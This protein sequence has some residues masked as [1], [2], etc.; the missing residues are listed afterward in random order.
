MEAR[1]FFK[2]ELH[3]IDLADAEADHFRCKSSAA[4]IQAALSGNYRP[5]H[6]FALQQALELYDIRR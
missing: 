2:L 1:K 4:T 6:V 5:E 3:G